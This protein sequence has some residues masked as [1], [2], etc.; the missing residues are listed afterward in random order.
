MNAIQILG[1]TRDYGGRRVVDHLELSVPAGELFALLGVNGA[2]KS[3]T[4]RKIGR[5][6]V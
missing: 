4:I 2:G 6:H 1:L 5:A 3:T